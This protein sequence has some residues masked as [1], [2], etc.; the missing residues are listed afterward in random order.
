[1][2]RTKL[3][4]V[5]HRLHGS[6]GLIGLAGVLLVPASAPAQTVLQRE[7][8]ALS[9]DVAGTAVDE[10][11]LAV[12]ETAIAAGQDR[13]M[14][15]YHV[16]DHN[17]QRAKIGYAVAYLDNGNWTWEQEGMIDPM[18]Y[19]TIGLTD[20]SVAVD[21]L[22]GDFLVCAL[23]RN[24]TQI[25]VARYTRSDDQMGAWEEIGPV[26]VGFDKPWIVASEVFVPGGPAAPGGPGATEFYITWFGGAP[27]HLFYLRSRNAGFDWAGG[28][29][30]RD[31]NDPSSTIP[32]ETWPV[33]SVHATTDPLYVAFKNG[34]DVNFVRAVDVNFG[35]HA[36]KALF[37]YLL[38]TGD[39]P[40]TVTRI[41]NSASLWMKVPHIGLV[42]PRGHCLDLAVDPTNTNRLFLAYSDLQSSTSNDVDVYLRQLTRNPV[43]GRWSVGTQRTVNTDESEFDADQILPK[44][45]VGVDGTIHVAFCDE[46]RW[47]D[48]DDFDP[49]PLFYDVY[50]ARSIDQ[51]QIWTNDELFGAPPDPPAAELSNPAVPAIGFLLGDYIGIDV[52]PDNV[53]WTSFMGTS[54]SDTNSNKSVI[55]SSRVTP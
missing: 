40:L 32:L 33:P 36:G 28:D 21:P 53:V 31:L 47:P 25:V 10:S 16:W 20:P 55:W 39:Q 5:L 2:D 3:T 14:S 42:S 45:A 11:T 15:V 6:L 13:A 18:T 54:T 46:R 8:A 29:A 19:D 43:T 9:L 12:W 26:G 30:L 50:Y 41:I 4:C 38:D 23:L 37:S 24:L 34:Y 52:D 27:P 48:Q 17:V 51:G 44:I 35:P 1:M 7:H 49:S 22:S